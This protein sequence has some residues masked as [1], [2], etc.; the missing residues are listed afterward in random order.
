MSEGSLDSP[1]ELT[2]A[3]STPTQE[4]SGPSPKRKRG[5]PRKSEQP[6]NAFSPSDPQS[7]GMGQKVRRVLNAELKKRG[8]PEED[9]PPQLQDTVTKRSRKGKAGQIVVRALSGV[10]KNAAS[11]LARR[12]EN[13]LSGGKEDVV[14]KLQASGNTS[15]ALARVVETLQV[16]PDFSLARAIAEAGADVAV[17]LDSYAKGALALKKLETV[18]ELYKQM[19]HLMKDLMRHAVDRKS[20]CDVCLGLKV[21]QSRAN[22]TQLSRACPRCG[23]EGETFESSEHKEFAA[24]KLLEISEMLP[25]KGGG[26]AVNVGVQ[27]NNPGGSEDLLARLSKSADEILYGQRTV[28]VGEEEVVDAEVLAQE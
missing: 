8:I 25:K 14:E 17:V 7:L 10:Q 11:Q 26:M 12:L 3:P 28:G 16:R 1:P 2:S 13:E 21:V 6:S 27:V 23:G 19:P 18:L 20:T 5:R 24:N 15:Q 4:E 22:G 9:L